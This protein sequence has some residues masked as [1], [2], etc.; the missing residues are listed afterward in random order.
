[1]NTRRSCILIF[2]NGEA[3]GYRLDIFSSSFFYFFFFFF[4]FFLFL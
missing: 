2:A 4:F 3:V 1:M